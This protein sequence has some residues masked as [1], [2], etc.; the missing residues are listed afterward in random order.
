MKANFLKLYAKAKN[1]KDYFFLQEV[2]GCCSDFKEFRTYLEDILLLKN[3]IKLDELKESIG[4]KY[5]GIKPDEWK[6]YKMNL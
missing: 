2:R 3:T 6:T 1:S 5:R 4:A